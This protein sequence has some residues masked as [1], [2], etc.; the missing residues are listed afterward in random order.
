MLPTM[1]GW[2]AAVMGLGLGVACADA[3]F[4]CAGDHQCSLSGTPGVCVDQGQCAYPDP[5]CASGLSF[6]LGS[7][8]NQAG[9][10]VGG[11]GSGGVGSSTGSDASTD[12]P[13]TD[14]STGGDVDSS[15]SGPLECDDPYEPNDAVELGTPILLGGC[16][17]EWEAASADALDTDWFL[18]GNP[19]GCPLS[20][21]TT[22]ATNPPRP[23]CIL[24]ACPN[25]LPVIPEECS[26]DLVPLLGGVACCATGEAQ[27][28]ATCVGEEPVLALRVGGEVDA[29]QCVPYQASF[30]L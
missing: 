24:P 27:L 12:S 30:F 16:V 29:P 23:V 11:Q 1:R 2:L 8:S 28:T 5:D 4:E 22:F 6:P 20:G 21:P 14:S 10:C 15:G 19:R 13:S 25:G 7:S 18:L 9:E 26:G 3:S 17:A